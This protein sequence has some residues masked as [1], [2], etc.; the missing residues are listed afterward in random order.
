MKLKSFI[1]IVSILNCNAVYAS[2]IPTV[3]IVGN[4]QEV[5]QGILT[6]NEWAKQA[7]RY[8]EE[9]AQAK[10]QLSEIKQQGETYKNMV[11]GNW[12][13]VGSLLLDPS[14]INIL[15]DD[16]SE[17]LN[18]NLTLSSLGSQLKQTYNLNSYNPVLDNQYSAK[19]ERLSTL[20]KMYKS[21]VKTTENLRSLKNK[22]AVAQTPY[23][24]A[25][26]QNTIN[27]E[28]AS[29]SNQQMKQN[30]YM[31]MQDQSNELKQKQLE[32]RQLKEFNSSFNAD[33]QESKRV[34]L[35]LIA[36]LSK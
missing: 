24:K 9:Y 30:I 35:S 31:Q 11:S 1:L 19:T 33:P 2:G 12:A 32:N 36:N 15:P 6:V 8:K 34:M 5:R 18:G 17:I 10:N 7:Q 28:V 20:D 23:E 21:R 25:D 3:D 26:L 27:L 22:L 4:L 16:P 29:L 13:N 14:I